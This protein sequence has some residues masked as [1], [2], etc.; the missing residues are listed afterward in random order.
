MGASAAGSALSLPGLLPPRE[1]L[2]GE[3]SA[4]QRKTSSAQ[5]PQR[6]ASARAA[7]GR[8][9]CRLTQ[10]PGAAASHLAP[11]RSPQTPRRPAGRPG[12]APAV[13]ALGR[14][15][16]ALPSRC[17]RAAPRP[18]GRRPTP[19]PRGRRGGAGRATETGRYPGTAAAA[20]GRG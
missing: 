17:R 11:A 4:A 7:A 20:P 12:R 8:R 1:S 13:S 18:F 6:P 3:D 9:R 2:E 5:R 14:C 10:A 19:A 15:A 16:G